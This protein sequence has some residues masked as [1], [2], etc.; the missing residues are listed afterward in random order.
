MTKYYLLEIS[1]DYPES[2]WFKFKHP[3]GVDTIEFS[4]SKNIDTEI[5][6]TFE[7]TLKKPS[8]KILHHDFFFSDGP[9]FISPKFSDLIRSEQITGLQLMATSI[10]INKEIHTGYNIF[11]VTNKCNCFNEK[12]SSFE[13]LI[14]YLPDGPRKYTSISLDQIAT[15]DTDVFRAQEDFTRIVVSQRF[16]DL[17]LSNNLNGLKFVE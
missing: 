8:S 14:P 10:A 9:N 5:E 7:K 4:Q 13:P 12:K 16:R 17:C 6:T 11:V 1:N 2:H 3:K 15:H